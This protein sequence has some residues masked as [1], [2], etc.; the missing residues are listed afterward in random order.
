[1]KYASQYFCV[2]Y[3]LDTL[4]ILGITPADYDKFMH[5]YALPMKE[6]KQRLIAERKLYDT[7]KYQFHALQSHLITAIRSL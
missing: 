6:I 5:L 7:F 2:Y 4:K 1:M 3:P